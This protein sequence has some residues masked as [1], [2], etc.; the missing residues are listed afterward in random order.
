MDL[1]HLLIEAKQKVPPFLAELCS[2]NEKYLEL[3]GKFL[4]KSLNELYLLFVFQANMGAVIVVVL[5]IELQ[6]VRNWRLFKTNKHLILEEEIIWQTLRLI[7]NVLMY[8]QSL[9]FIL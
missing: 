9:L 3:G 8:I 7:T 1:K 5:A 6:T 2:E 4:L